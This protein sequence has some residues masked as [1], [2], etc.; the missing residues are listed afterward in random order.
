[1]LIFDSQ[2]R[3]KT[4]QYEEG[5]YH[6]EHKTNEEV[7]CPP[8]VYNTR[9]HLPPPS[10]TYEPHPRAPVHRELEYSQP[11]DHHTYS[12]T[13][14]HLN[15]LSHS[16]RSRQSNHF[17]E[18]PNM[19]GHPHSHHETLNQ[20]NLKP[21]RVP[22]IRNTLPPLPSDVNYRTIPPRTVGHPHF[23]N[24]TGTNDERAMAALA[25]NEHKPFNEPV[26]RNTRN[27]IRLRFES[28]HS[29]CCKN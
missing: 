22:A 15:D 21:L 27:S 28:N 26:Y 17:A 13:T 23:Q 11:K 4:G 6:A 20:M 19:L 18:A 25:P 9:S 24:I 3:F 12:R 8:P 16:L 1:M 7:H 10:Y 2:K 29:G 5:H 14:P